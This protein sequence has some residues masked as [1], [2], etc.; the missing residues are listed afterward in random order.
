MEL[1]KV[2]FEEENL[3]YPVINNQVSISVASYLLHGILTNSEF[4]KNLDKYR[5]ENNLTTS[6][7]VDLCLDTFMLPQESLMKPG[8]YTEKDIE[9]LYHN[10]EIGDEDFLFF[11]YSMAAVRNQ[12]CL[13]SK[14]EEENMAI[15][16]ELVNKKVSNISQATF[17]KFIPMSVKMLITLK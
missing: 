2:K 17:L 1:L 11:L 15:I 13:L 10:K 9:K 12:G 16:Y 3:S 4:S 14:L 7:D 6:V 8:E 5:E